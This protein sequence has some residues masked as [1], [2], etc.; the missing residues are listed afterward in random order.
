MRGRREDLLASGSQTIRGLPR[1][2]DRTLDTANN[3]NR[4]HE[5]EH[6]GQNRS[7]ADHPVRGHRRCFRRLLP[8]AEQ[9]Q[10]VLLRVG[11]DLAD[12]IHALFAAIRFHQFQSLFR[13]VLVMQVNGALEFVQL[14]VDEC[15]ERFAE[16]SLLV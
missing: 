14:V 8:L 5:N 6:E 11:H 13:L 9:T 12:L 4:G 3:R 7:R 15:L 10:L 2:A 1:H 16:A